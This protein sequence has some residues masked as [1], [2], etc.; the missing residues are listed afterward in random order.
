VLAVDFLP[1]RRPTVRY[2]DKDGRF[3]LVL[4]VANT[5][6]ALG[7]NARQVVAARLIQ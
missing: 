5:W 3:V 2:P 7:P 4:P 1:F 6:P